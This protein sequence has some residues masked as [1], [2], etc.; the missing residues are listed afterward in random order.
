MQVPLWQIG[1]SL[2]G[3]AVSAYVMVLLATRFFRAG[4]LLSS[5]AFSWGTFRDGLAQIGARLKAV[6]ASWNG[7][8]K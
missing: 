6:N 1:L 3:V 2:L 7:G 5:E 8:L 4:K